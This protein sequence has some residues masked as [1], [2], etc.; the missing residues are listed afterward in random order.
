MASTSQKQ[1]NYGTTRTLLRAGF[2]TE[3]DTLEKMLSIR[4][5]INNQMPNVTRLSSRDSVC[6]WEKDL[7]DQPSLQQSTKS[8]QKQA[9]FFSDWGKTRV[10]GLMKPR[11]NF[12]PSPWASRLEERTFYMPSSIAIQWS[13][14]VTT[15]SWGPEG[16]EKAQGP[17]LQ[18][19][20]LSSPF[21]TLVPARDLSN[22]GKKNAP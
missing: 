21:L 22:K 12:S 8:G 14:V 5:R 7:K 9:V 4:D 15:S 10:F 1:K 3:P 20:L 13:V 2:L 17:W 18:S 19:G 16:L 11:L 6:R